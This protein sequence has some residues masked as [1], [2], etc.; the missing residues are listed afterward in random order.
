MAKEYYKPKGFDGIGSDIK[1]C[2]RVKGRKKCCL[3]YRYSELEIWTKE[4]N[5]FYLLRWYDQ[6]WYYEE[7]AHY[8][9]YK[10]N[11]LGYISRFK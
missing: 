6:T 1:W 4:W 8:R 2:S 7:Y 9:I 10:P 5:W 3:C 11:K